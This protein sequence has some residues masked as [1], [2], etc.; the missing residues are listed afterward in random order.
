M[1]SIVIPSYNR[2]D[3]MLALLTDVYRQQ[4]VEFEVIVVDDCSPD[5]SVEAIRRHFPA[6]RLFVNKSNGGPAVTRNKGIRE[7]C[8]ELIVGF[9]SDVTLPD[10]L[11]LAKV[12]AAFR[13]SEPPQGLAFRIYKPDGISED[14]GRWW[15]PLPIA[16]HADKLFSTSYFSG[17]AYA[18]HRNAVMAA[19]LFPELLYMHYEEV[20]LAWR[21]LDRGGKILYTPAISVV[22]HANP[23]SRRSEV[24][25]F[26]KPRNQVLLAAGCLPLPEA[27][28]Y[29]LPRTSFQCFKALISGHFPEFV[30]AMRSAMQLIPRQLAAR[31][32]LRRETLARIRSLK[33]PEPGNHPSAKSVQGIA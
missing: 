19:G 26:Y 9:D 7:A 24:E 27:I 14:V 22:H 31:K 15:H 10:P 3:G 21:I 16:D 12:S 28:C 18:F 33:F 13:E 30:R 8:G 20:E 1:I 11:L 25:L 4:D 6:V 5:D 2:R 29:L 23:V 17:T 32:P